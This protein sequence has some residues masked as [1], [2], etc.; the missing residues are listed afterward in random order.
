MQ[1]RKPNLKVRKPASYTSHRHHRPYIQPA[2]PG[3]ATRT[4]TQT[5]YRE[6]PA[7]LD[8]SIEGLMRSRH[9]L[10]LPHCRRAGRWR[11][12]NDA[13]GNMHADAAVPPSQHTAMRD[14]RGGRETIRAEG[15]SADGD[16][17]DP[18]NRI[19]WMPDT[20]RITEK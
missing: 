12:V 11:G 17:A 10:D 15:H 20:Y 13:Y 14:Q 3:P 19:E 16:A 2:G 7:P 8:L 6:P 18:K 5:R 4:K 9:E 1:D